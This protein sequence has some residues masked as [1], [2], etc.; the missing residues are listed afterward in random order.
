MNKART[1]LYRICTYRCTDLWLLVIITITI[2]I[3]VVIITV[4]VVVVIVVIIVIVVVITIVVVVIMRLCRVILRV[5][6]EYQIQCPALRWIKKWKIKLNF[7][8]NEE[9]LDVRNKK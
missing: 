6:F 7:E 9:K 2:I 4:I 5:S 3:I 1:S 8:K